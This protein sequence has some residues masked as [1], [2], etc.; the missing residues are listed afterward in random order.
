MCE[1]CKQLKKENLKLKWWNTRL[2]SLLSE[3]SE[4]VSLMQSPWRRES[5]IDHAYN[6]AIGRAL[7][8]VSN[9]CYK[10]KVPGFGAPMKRERKKNIKPNVENGF[11]Q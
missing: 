10:G 4:S 3:V 5:D 9:A 1:Q 8:C 7:D 6:V 11:E 2:R